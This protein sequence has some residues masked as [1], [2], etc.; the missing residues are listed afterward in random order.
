MWINQLRLNNSQT[1]K[2]PYLTWFF[3]PLAGLELSVMSSPAVGGE[4]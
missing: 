1:L 3:P 2:N 4:T